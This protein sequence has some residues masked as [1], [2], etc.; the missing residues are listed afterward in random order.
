M[1][2]WRS[3]RSW[4]ARRAP[5][6]E[7]GF[8]LLEISVAVVLLGLSTVV[9]LG[10]LFTVVRSSKITTDQSRVEAVLTNAAERLTS[11]TYVPCPP[12]SGPGSYLSVVQSAADT[13][14]WPGSTVTIFGVRY[15]NPTTSTWSTSNDASGVGCNP[16]VTATSPRT[17]QKISVRVTVPTGGYN[18]ALEVVKNNVLADP[19]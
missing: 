8:T 2:T 16:S 5:K 11:T 3:I 13:V 14:G 10:G 7:Q 19:S 17:I 15:W 9:I 12:A 6:D 4:R 1:R 18:R